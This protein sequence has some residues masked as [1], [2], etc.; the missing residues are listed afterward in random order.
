MVV[1]VVMVVIMVAVVIAPYFKKRKRHPYFP[2]DQGEFFL[3][4]R[5]GQDLLWLGRV[6]GDPG[7]DQEK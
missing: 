6:Q 4:S 7:Q 5:V 3:S 1:V 2:Q